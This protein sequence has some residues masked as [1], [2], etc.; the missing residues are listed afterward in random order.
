MKIYLSCDIEGLAGISMFE[1]E[2]Q[3]TQN[4]RELYHKHI[5]WVLTGIQSSRVNKDITEITIAD[6]H[7]KG[8]NLNYL[9]LSEMDD[10]ISLING[11]PR[12][13]YMMSGLDES[14]D[15]VFFVGYHAG[16]GKRYGNMDHGYSAR[17]AYDLKINGEYMNETTI[18]AAYAGELGVPVGLV[19][20]DSALEEQLIQDGMMPNVQF[21][22]TKQSLARY[23]CMSY[24]MKQVKK[25]IIDSTKEVLEKDLSALPLYQLSMPAKVEIQCATTAQADQMEMLA[26]V[27]RIDGR[28]IAFSNDS[29]E[30]TMNQI[31]ALVGLGGSV[32]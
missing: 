10:R 20:G 25:Q 16:I 21:V 15:V 19:I 6:S 11:F 12:K 22:V 23:A 27:E 7:S 4:F 28:G 17:V 3:D 29:M 14:Y 30:E 24:P 13:N 18:N 9:R 8:I 31:V 32:N 2:H 5:E 26:F 1:Q